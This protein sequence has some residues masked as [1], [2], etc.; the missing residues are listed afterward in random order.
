MIEHIFN[1]W[2]PMRASLIL[3]ILSGI[4]VCVAFAASSQKILWATNRIIPI[5]LSASIV[6]HVFGVIGRMI[7][8]NRPP[9]TNL[10]DSILFVGLVGVIGLCAMAIAKRD[11][12]Y[13]LMAVFTG[14]ILQLIALKFDAEGDTLRVLSAVLDTNFWLATHVVVITCGYA[15]SIMTA[16]L[17]HAA[18]I[19]RIIKPTD[20]A[21]ASNL[22]RTTN[23]LSF[24]ALFTTTVGTILGGIW[25]DQSWGRFWGWDPKENGALLIVLW[26][27]WV[28]HGRISGI[29]REVG[30]LGLLAALNIIVALAWFGVNL[31][32]VGLHSYG[33]TEN[34]TWGLTLFCLI[35]TVLII[36]AV[37][38]IKIKQGR[39]V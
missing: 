26:L 21:R 18:L 7:I 11:H 28:L 15:T 30:I 33:F 9:V 39:V 8:L 19:H 13:T 5:I 22:Y 34:A 31:L 3:Y 24:V 36:T 1:T 27:I 4:L 38:F 17:A 10:Y 25:A 12:L 20:T 37:S 35:Q 14:T 2:N 32:G 6:L 23:T 29:L 16:M